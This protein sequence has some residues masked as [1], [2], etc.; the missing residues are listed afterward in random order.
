MNIS[1]LVLRYFEK[2]PK[3][4]VRKYGWKKDLHDPRDLRYKVSVPEAPRVLP[5]LVDLRP[6]CPPVYDQL[7]LGSC[8]GNAIASAFQFEQMK[9][10]VPNWIPSRLFIYYNERVIEKTINEDAGAQIRNGIKSVV[11][12]GVC[13]ETM[14]EYNVKKFTT[15]P[16]KSCYREALNNQVI[17]YERIAEHTLQGVKEALADGYSVVFGFTVY[18]SMETPEVAKSGL[19]PVPSIND[20]PVG[21]HAVKAVGYDDSK[22]CLIVKNSWGIDWGMKGYFYLPYWYITTPNAAADFWVIKLVESKNK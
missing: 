2:A 7:D 22:E 20:K 1:D 5:S 18:D 13:P 4:I 16:C 19:V 9:Q 21:G 6:F 10:K 15:K 8:T 11:D 3:P 14:W 17:Q 12:S